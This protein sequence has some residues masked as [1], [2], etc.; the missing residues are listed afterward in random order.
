MII[1]FDTDK[2]AV[3]VCSLLCNSPA[4]EFYMPTFR[5]VDI[6]FRRRGN[7]PEENIQHTEHGESLKSKSAVVNCYG[8]FNLS[9]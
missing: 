3:V 9:C 8:K 1:E 5:N 7:Y 4:S 6:K 2:S